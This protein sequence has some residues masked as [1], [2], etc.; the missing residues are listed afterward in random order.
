MNHWST[1][2]T[3]SISAFTLMLT[4][5]FV[6]ES[7]MS[8]LSVHLLCLEI[9]LKVKSNA[10]HNSLLWFTGSY[11]CIQI[12]FSCAQCM[13]SLQ[14]ICTCGLFAHPLGLNLWSVCHWAEPKTT[15][16]MPSRNNFDYNA[17]LSNPCFHSECILGFLLTLWSFSPQT[18][19][20][21]STG[22]VEDIFI[23]HHF[24]RLWRTYIDG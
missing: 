8:R 21:I 18:M 5:N 10:S 1:F 24:L 9:L 3:L 12:I 14:R 7:L 11:L 17:I 16:R 15:T 6:G 4:L 23:I 2:T 13:H 22:K 20:E 19:A